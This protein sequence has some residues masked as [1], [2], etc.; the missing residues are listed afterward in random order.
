MAGSVPPQG[1]R[2]DYAAVAE[3]LCSD[4]FFASDVRGGSHGTV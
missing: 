2:A 4:V 3:S 1:L